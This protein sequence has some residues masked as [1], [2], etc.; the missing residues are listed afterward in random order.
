MN[1]SVP[2]L[3]GK[4]G[5]ALLI[6]LVVG[7]AWLALLGFDWCMRFAWFRWQDTWV[8]RHAA[9]SGSESLRPAFAVTNAVHRGDDL[10][11][12]IGIPSVASLYEEDRP[13]SVIWM[14][15]YG[16]KNV[17][18]TAGKRFPIVV[19]GDSFMEDGVTMDD[20]FPARLSEVSGLPVY[21]HALQGWGLFLSLVRF[22]ESER[23]RRDPPRVLVWGVI[24]RE[25]SG[26]YFEGLNYQ[27]YAL[28]HATG[29]AVAVS[30][31]S[32]A[33]FRPDALKKALP[34]TSALAQ[35]SSRYW[36]VIRYRV[37]GRLNP[38]VIP[39][40]QRIG[41]RRM[42]FYYPTIDAMSWSPAIRDVARVAGAV[43]Y[44][45]RVVAGRGIRLV[46]VLIPDK[47]QVYREYIPARYNSPER[48]LPDSCLNGLERALLACGIGVV[49]LLPVFRERAQS[50]DLLYWADDTHWNPAGIRLAAET[51]WAYIRPLAGAAAPAA[52]VPEP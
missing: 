40:E 24:E 38:Y 37:L 20:R 5:R 32:L 29:S 46:V 3:D 30:G 15:E 22:L 49:N 33:S 45:N 18:P 14:D 7:F 11:Y 52:P 27:L 51:T 19:A 28:E 10:T 8:L 34:N 1:R 13:A 48:P 16:Y 4:R 36:N 39:I 9:V 26:S 25:I 42:L 31:T 44:L 6:A 35:L 43:E 50:G 47:E 23:F 21:N 41:G 12:L 2:G 17:P